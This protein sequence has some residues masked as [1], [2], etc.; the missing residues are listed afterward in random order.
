[1]DLR[2][3]FGILP[4]KL[5]YADLDA[6]VEAFPIPPKVTLLWSEGTVADLS[7]SEGDNVK[8]GQELT[9]NEK[10][11]FVSTVTGQVQEIK[12]F[13]GADGYEYVA[14]VINANSKDSFDP[15]SS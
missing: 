11:S 12:T 14:V 2:S 10:G 7:I 8:T 1:M 4:P 5:P 13:L 3:F 9:K 15:S 6:P